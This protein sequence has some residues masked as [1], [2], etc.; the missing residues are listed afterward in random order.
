MSIDDRLREAHQERLE[1]VSAAADSTSFTPADSTGGARLA[2]AAALIV[3][4]GLTAGAWLL[5][6]SPTTPVDVADPN[7]TLTTVAPIQPDSPP[8]TTGPSTTTS[9]PTTTTATTA[10]SSTPSTDGQPPEND[11]DTQDSATTVPATT[12]PPTTPT[13]T[14]TTTPP[15]TTSSPTTIP[16]PNP[17][18]ASARCPS[19]H[20]AVLEDATLT[21]VGENEGWGR[22]ADL[23]D[24]QDTQFTFEAW[25]PGYPNEVTVSVALDEPVL[26]VDIRVAQDPFTPVSGLIEITAT[27]NGQELERFDIELEGVDGWKA[28]SFEP[29]QLLDGFTITRRNAEANIMEVMVCVAD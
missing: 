1:H 3:L 25:E 14:P 18:V 8:T 20:R 24:E 4:A 27:L 2:V 16:T 19:G 29:P 28:H 26:A 15:P 5:Q 11:S 13:P 17:G 21:Y 12:T 9:A 22:L 7:P 6:R 10:P 23:V